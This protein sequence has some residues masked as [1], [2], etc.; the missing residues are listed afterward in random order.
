MRDYKRHGHDQK[1]RELVCQESGDSKSKSQLKSGDDDLIVE[2][3]R[4]LNGSIIRASSKLGDTRIPFHTID[5]AS[6]LAEGSNRFLCFQF[7]KVSSLVGDAADERC[8]R[9]PI[10]I[11]NRCRKPPLLQKLA[12]R[13]MPNSDARVQRTC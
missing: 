4:Y 13:R 6:M 11:E 3:S 5:V 2:Y 8:A 12:S 10:S 7:A 9:L 1:D